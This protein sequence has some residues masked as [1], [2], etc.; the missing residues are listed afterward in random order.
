MA[1]IDEF[2]DINALLNAE[3]NS[4]CRMPNGITILVNFL[5]GRDEF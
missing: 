4:E 5:L 3:P 1:N 2:N